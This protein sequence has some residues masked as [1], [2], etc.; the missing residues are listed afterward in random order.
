MTVQGT[1]T[2]QAGRILGDRTLVVQDTTGGIPVRLPSA[3]LADDYPRGSIIRATGELAAPYGNLELR[4]ADASDITTLGRGGLP[5]ARALASDGLAEANEGILATLTA[6]ITSID[7]YDSGAVSI[8][9]ADAR[10][11]GKVYAFAPVG[12]GTGTLERDQRVRAIGIVGQRA[13]STGAADGYR[14]WLRGTADLTVVAPAP[15]PTP[16][17]PPGDD[18]GSTEQ[19]PRRVA[20]ADAIAG[21]TVVIVGVVTSPAGLVDAEA[22]RVT[23]QDRSGAILVR[24][25][26]DS[27]PARVGSVIRAVGEVGS[28]F[29]TRQLEA[30]QAPRRKRGGTVR[31]T[32][33]KRVPTEADEWR[34]VR[35]AVR[36]TDVERSDDTWRA[37]A[38]LADGSTLPVIGLAGARIDADLLEPGRLARVSGI[39]RR[40]HPSAN[41]QRFAV[42][43]RSRKDIRLGRLLAPTTRTMVRTTTAAMKT[44][45]KDGRWTAVPAAAE[46]L[47]ATFGAL[48]GLEDRLVRVGGRVEA[49]SERSLRLDDGTAAGTVRLDDGSERFQPGFTVGEVVNAV[50]RVRRHRLR[51]SEVVLESPADLRRAASLV[52]AAPVPPNDTEPVDAAPDRPGTEGRPSRSAPRSP[53]GWCR[54]SSVWRWSPCRCWPRASP[55]SS[56]GGALAPTLDGHGARGG[57]PLVASGVEARQRE[58]GRFECIQNASLLAHE[59]CRDDGVVIKK[60]SSLLADATR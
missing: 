32:T 52:G 21:Q 11:A 58:T 9:V 60:V 39:V 4:P 28:W 35:V 6:T 23:V 49:V 26:A 48:D 47:A 53:G 19:Q 57:P 7:R 50:G 34:L 36:I 16:S 25:P 1:V 8:E 10:G 22:R 59:R 38:E 41:D 18:G 17:T 30:E 55:G 51:G 5:D 44:M 31:P 2:A 37:E 56:P 20:I 43:P 14:L 33:L 3:G 24:Y 42:A 54:P 13:S 45:R 27:T 15:T 12:L 40:A 46:V 29:G